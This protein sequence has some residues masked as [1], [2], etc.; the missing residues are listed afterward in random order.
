MSDSSAFSFN[1]ILLTLKRYR[2][3]HYEV[4][5]VSSEIGEVIKKGAKFYQETVFE[6]I[7]PALDKPVF[8]Y[9]FQLLG[10]GDKIITPLLLGKEK[11]QLV[12]LEGNVIAQEDNSYLVNLLLSPVLWRTN[13]KFSWLVEHNTKNVFSGL[14]YGDQ[15]SHIDQLLEFLYRKFDFLKPLSVEELLFLR[16]GDRL[17]VFP[18]HL[19]LSTTLFSAD[20]TMIMLEYA[21]NKN[22]VDPKHLTDRNKA[23]QGE[24]LKQYKSLFNENPLPVFQY[25]KSGIVKEANKSFL[26]KLGVRHSDEIIGTNIIDLFV[27]QPVKEV[28]SDSIADGSGFYEGPFYSPLNDKLFHVRV[29]AKPVDLGENFMAILEDISEQEY[30]HNVLSHFTEKT[31][32]FSGKRF[33]EEI[34]GYLSA[35][36][37]L[38]ICYIAEIDNELLTAIPISYFSQGTNTSPQ[39]VIELK[40][41]AVLACIQSGDP[42]IVLKDAFKIFPDD[43]SLQNQQ[44]ST[45]LAI[46]IS[47]MENDR[48][49]I[50]VIMDT[51]SAPI[52]P[53]I[54]ELLK[55]I[56]DRIGAELN[57]MYFENRLVA[58]EQLFSSIAENFPKGTIE[59]LDKDL[60]Y[61]YTEGKEYQAMGLDPKKLV[62]TPHLAKYDNDIS[63]NIRSFLN[64]VLQGESVIFEARN[65]DQ[66]Y[67]KSGVPLVNNSGEIDRI[68]IVTQNITETKL[69]EEERE[70]LIKDLKSQNEE[71]QRFAYII[72]HNLRAPIVNISSLLDLYDTEN[73]MDTDNPEIIEN[74]K[75]STDLLN[76]TLKD[77]IEVVSIKKNKIPKVEVVEFM[78]LINNIERSLFQQIRESKTIIEKDFSEAPKINYIYSH[79]EN[80]L[81]NLTTNS[82]KY[83]HPERS[84]EISIKTYREG[85]Y[86]VIRFQDNGIGLDLKRYGDRL[87]GLYQRFHSHVEGKGLGLYLVRE[88]IRAH[89]GNLQV[90]SV[91][92]QGST[93]WIYLHNLKFGA[94]E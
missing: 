70:Q 50:L 71:L 78:N 85:V 37:K 76:G 86:T 59:V 56:G 79:L 9:L 94:F 29:N 87:F 77:L 5:Y 80:F 38:N 35:S 44:I 93:F 49:A 66:H 84:P 42:L 60:I 89:D 91:L 62:G 6:Q 22:E 41:T 10:N 48:C 15:I 39:G 61:V 54:K 65:G 28:F 64:R 45:F 67:L 47:D 34:T 90:E 81:L 82:I 32:R 8:E 18:G 72:S 75:Y 83:R 4:L 69:A 46:P 2:D 21:A 3:G 92:G 74:L 16:H 68:L 19:Y 58:S 7:L 88:Q 12:Q 27:D 13:I 52:G 17:P 51:K 25:N 30:F 14:S 26:Q 55:V 57:R 11:F 53:G 24:N 33:C 36:L 23:E 31:S 40:D 1:N 73:P 20:Y 43:L 63:K